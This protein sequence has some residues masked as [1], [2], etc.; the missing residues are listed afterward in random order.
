MFRAPLTRACLLAQS[1]KRAGLLF[2]TT[3]RTQSNAPAKAPEKIEVFI[4]DQPVMVLPGT[5]VLQVNIF[6]GTQQ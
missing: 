4:D 6:T 3:S 5:T 2:T 1:Q